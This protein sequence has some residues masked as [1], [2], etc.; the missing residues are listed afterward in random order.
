MRLLVM[1]VVLLGGISASAIAAEPQRAA[2]ARS[3]EPR[4]IIH[5]LGM[6]QGKG[7]VTSVLRCRDAT[8]APLAER[9]SEPRPLVEG[10][11]TVETPAATN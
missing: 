9:E 6:P 2:T 10:A 7:V 4:C 3:P 1:S 11:S 8:L 5:H